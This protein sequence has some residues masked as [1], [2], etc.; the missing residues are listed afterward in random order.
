M[1]GTSSTTTG[2]QHAVLW[3]R[4]G[5]ATDLGTVPSDTDSY[6]GF[7]TDGGLMVGVSVL[8]GRRTAVLWR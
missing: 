5:A 7:I 8:N 6:G 2:T 3:D 1:I 4:E